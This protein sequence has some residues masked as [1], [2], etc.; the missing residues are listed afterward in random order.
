MGG[1][2]GGRPRRERRA[3][4]RYAPEEAARAARA[5]PPPGWAGP[6]GCSRCRW[7]AQGCGGCNPDKGYVPPPPPSTRSSR[8]AARAERRR[9]EASPPLPRWGARGARGKGRRP[10]VSGAFVTPMTRLLQQKDTDNC[11]VCGEPWCD[12]V[13]PILLC[14]GCDVPVHQFCYGIDE[15]V[16]KSDAPWYCD[17][18]LFYR[19]NKDVHRPAE[20][21]PVCAL[22]PAP[23]GALRLLSNH[24]VQ[25]LPRHGMLNG[26]R[27]R[28]AH[29][30]CI[31]AVPE[32]YC[33]IRGTAE[34]HQFFGETAAVDPERWELKCDL[35]KIPHGAPVQCSAGN[36][37]LAFHPLCARAA[38]QVTQFD[39]TGRLHVFC[40]SHST[41]RYAT[42]RALALDVGTASQ[43]IQ[44]KREQAAAVEAKMREQVAAATGPRSRWLVQNWATFQP[45]QKDPRAPPPAALLEAAGRRPPGDDDASA[46]LEA[47]VASLS[48]HGTG[49]PE[50][51]ASPSAVAQ[52]KTVQGTLRGYQLEGLRWLVRQAEKGLGGI[53]GDEMGL[54]KTLQIIAFLA[55]RKAHNNDTGPHLI[56]APLSVLDSWMNE[57]RRW[58]PSMKVVS[59]QGTQNERGRIREEHLRANDFEV[60]VTTYET[61]MA[62]KVWL[63]RS[64]YYSHVILDEA[65][66]VKNMESQL[67]G[68]IFHMRSV[69]RVL[70]TGTPLQN[71]LSE[72][73]TLLRFL[74]P[75]AVHPDSQRAFEKGFVQGGGSLQVE[76]SCVRAAHCLLQ[77]LML[78]RTKAEVLAQELP[79]KHEEV[80]SIEMADVQKEIYRKLLEGEGSIGRLAELNGVLPVGEKEPGKYSNR[81]RS[82]SNLLLQLRKCSLHPAL[83]EGEH[84]VQAQLSMDEMVGQSGKLKYLDKL[85]P[86][87]KMGGHKV[88]FF[89]AFTSFLDILEAYLA[90]R[91]HR[92]LRLDGSTSVARRRYETAV[93]N[94][95]GSG[96][97]AYLISLKAGG[98]GLNLQG[99]DTVI[100]MEPQ[101]NPTFEAQAQDRCHRIGQKRPVTVYRLCSHGSCEESILEVAAQK[102]QMSKAVMEDE[103]VALEP[104]AKLTF[105]EI[106]EVISRGAGTFLRDGANVPQKS[107]RVTRRSS[108][109]DPGGGKARRE[110]AQLVEGERSHWK[111]F[112]GVNYAGA[113][114]PRDIAEHWVAGMKEGRKR[115]RRSMNVEVDTHVF[116]LGTMSVSKWSIE[117]EKRE[118]QIEEKQRL[119]KRTAEEERALRVKQHE[120]L[121][122]HCHE[123]NVPGLKVSPWCPHNLQYNEKYL[124]RLCPRVIHAGCLVGSVGKT[125][126]ICQQ[127]KCQTCQRNSSD[128]GGLIFRCVCCPAA[129]CDECMRDGFEPVTSHPQWEAL[130]FKPS[131]N[132][133]YIRCIDCV[134]S[135]HQLPWMEAKDTSRKRRI[136]DVTITLKVGSSGKGST[137]RPSQ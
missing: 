42:A 137:S 30:A 4:E 41:P 39:P 109:S 80:V 126:Y 45:L 88:L 101:W 22:C 2:P 20:G 5:L 91:G 37:R 52:P 12:E 9:R 48:E 110:V 75:D 97:F 95:E 133:E 94:Q 25:R 82:L 73:W 40:A 7:A 3:V 99:A 70:L 23:W 103:E 24:S 49:A 47:R 128:C 113:T 27:A 72:L 67:A 100:I 111:S 115:Q 50:A 6:W 62:E 59:F 78:R 1:G 112:Q 26:Q 54:G 57:F 46:D 18:C 61:L 10:L 98:V 84:Q 56:V 35:C 83:F 17:A 130:G 53:L 60:L 65:H 8:S 58:C 64:F 116:G 19:R 38:G 44:A 119:K 108:E 90:D 96:Y 118:E 131:Q 74:V 76:K 13:N 125:G 89:S 11:H 104:Q 31:T 28:M 55:Y 33:K 68:A 21:V 32:A 69:R 63:W 79:P 117:R 66:R 136:K 123:A 85:L 87:L 77:A 29:A 34:E 93:F 14:D 71:N 114:G 106:V 135:G 86:Q 120:T 16:A 51:E 81:F 127:H 132:Y 36:C 15:S 129:F 124:C 134:E 102:V 107:G 122:I 92:A 105:K 43:K 121:C